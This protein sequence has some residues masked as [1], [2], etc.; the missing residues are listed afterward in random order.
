MFEHAKSGRECI[1]SK[2]SANERAN[3]GSGAPEIAP[4]D[5][6]ASRAIVIFRVSKGEKVNVTGRRKIWEIPWGFR[7]FMFNRK[8]G[9]RPS[10]R[11][12]SGKSTMS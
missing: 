1:N 9:I 12:R 8:E 10:V 11:R 3:R 6:P 7:Y 5:L 4:A 2:A